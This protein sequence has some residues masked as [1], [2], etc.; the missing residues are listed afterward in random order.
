M[1]K[2]TRVN[3]DGTFMQEDEKENNYV[4]LNENDF[5]QPKIEQEVRNI[6]EIVSK[7]KVIDKTILIAFL[8]DQTK[9]PKGHIRKII[10]GE[11]EFFRRLK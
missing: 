2:R 7:I 8:H 3:P 6:G 5:E 1:A 9:L 11:F 4:E 10:D